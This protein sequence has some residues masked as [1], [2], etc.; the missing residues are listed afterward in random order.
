M[1]KANKTSK[2]LRQRANLFW[3]NFK[4]DWQLHLMVLYPVL[5]VLIFSYGPM[6]GVQIAFRDYRPSTGILGSEW[7][8]LQW[9]EQFLTSFNFMAIFKNTIILSLYTLLVSFPLPII[10]ALILNAMTSKKYKKVAQTISYIPHFISTAVIVSIVTMVLSP[11][12]GIYGSMYRLFGGEGYPTDIRGLASSFRHIY[13]WSGIWQSL[14]WNSILYTSALSSVSME[15]HEA[16]MI[17]GASRFK[18]ILYVDIPAIAPTIGIK[19]ILACGSLVGVGFEKAY[20]LQNSLNLDVSEVISTYVYKQGFSSF[21]MYSYSSA[22]GLF[23]T[24]LN[25]ILLIAVNKIAKKI[26]DGEVAVL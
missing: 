22:V 6:Y 17:D 18:R 10:F 11:T 8:G 16:A 24:V 13:V 26:S 19:L 2:T 5:R 23:E 3:R 25:L 9:F 21:R 20:M 1:K 4:R 7:V 12:S 14:G 15:L